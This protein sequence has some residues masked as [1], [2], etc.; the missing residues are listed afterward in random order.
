MARIRQQIELARSYVILSM[1]FLYLVYFI[2]GSDLILS[3][4]AISAFLVFLVNVPYAR[5]APRVFSVIMFVVGMGINF[6]MQRGMDEIINGI[7]TNVPLLTL[8]MLVPLISIPLREG[9]YLDSVHFYM[10]R[11]V[12]Q[13]RKLFASISFFLFSLGPVLNLGSIRLLHDILKDVRL[14]SKLLAKAYLSGFST[15]ILWSPYFGS[16]ALVLF[17]MDLQVSEYIPVGMPLAI[18]MYAVGNVIFRLTMN[19]KVREEN[20]ALVAEQGTDLHLADIPHHRKNVIILA[21]LIAALMLSVLTLEA[22]THWSMMFL[23][24]M[25][26]LLFP[27]GWAVINRKAAALKRNW[28]DFRNRSVPSMS[29]EIV[30]FISAGIFGKSLTGTA[31]AEAISSAVAYISSISVLALAVSI[32]AVIVVLTFTGVHPIVVVIP[33]ITTIDPQAIGMAPPVIALVF[34]LS[35]SISAVASPVNPLNLLVSGSVS[36]PSLTVGVKWN[37]LYLLTLFVIGV[38]YIYILHQFVFS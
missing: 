17:F 37:G 15:V 3:I 1:S 35:W 23:V 33:L 24:S 21:L 16:V 9:G 6:Y 12:D 14:K 13:P 18:V 29:N 8:I 31:V 20:D 26:A 32:I 4:L 38:T 25:V 27:A 36:R 30:M 7:V 28:I 34:M 5:T 19:G 2:S 22:I 10:N 11:M